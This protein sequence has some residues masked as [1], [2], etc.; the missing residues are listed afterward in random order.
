LPHT[1]FSGKF[2]EILSK[3]FRNPKRWPASTPMSIVQHQQ[4]TVLT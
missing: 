3:I 2:E 4:W 1:N